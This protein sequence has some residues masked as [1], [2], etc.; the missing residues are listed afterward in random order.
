M[1]FTLGNI[2]FNRF[3]AYHP[4]NDDV[5]DILV[6]IDKVY[7]V[8][9]RLNNV[10]V[11]SKNPDGSIGNFLYTRDWYAYDTMIAEIC[12]SNSSV[13]IAYTLFVDDGVEYLVGWSADSN[14]I[15]VWEITSSAT[16]SSSRRWVYAGQER[17]FT[18]YSRAGWDGEHVWFWDNGTN[19]VFKW[20]VETR[21]YAQY[22]V[23]TNGN[24]NMNSSYTG[25]GLIVDQDFIYWGSGA[26]E[27]DP[28]VGAFRLDGGAGA[29]TFSSGNFQGLEN[30]TVGS[31]SSLPANTTA[32]FTPLH[33]DICYLIATNIDGV[34]VVEI[35]SIFGETGFAQNLEVVKDF[36]SG[37]EYY[38]TDEVDLAWTN[39]ELV[40]EKLRPVGAT[41]TASSNGKGGQ[42]FDEGKLFRAK[43]NKAL[44]TGDINLG[45]M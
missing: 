29:G 20:N 31:A 3:R 35:D 6:G 1:A 33:P 39:L 25:A 41:V 11:Y 4:L 17:A 15:L 45:G 7:C 32:Q 26:N 5:C 28:T 21:G 43:I 27:V 23:T 40:P 18:S 44:L 14:R 19:R 2:T 37:V 38:A 13:P 16:I 10:Y 22:V 30:N 36:E 34:Y 9:R 8:W 24:Y 42:T 12:R